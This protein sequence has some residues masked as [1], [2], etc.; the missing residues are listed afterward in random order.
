MI[1]SKEF[2]PVS[3]DDRLFSGCDAILGKAADNGF[4]YYTDGLILVLHTMV[5]VLISLDMLVPRPESLG[6]IRSNGNLLSKTQLISW[7][8]RS[9]IQMVK[10]P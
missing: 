1:K 3:S 5:L 9:K 4:D 2:Y 6:N 8:R 7:S 10:T